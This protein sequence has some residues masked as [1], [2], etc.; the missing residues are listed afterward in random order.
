MT[1]PFS[2]D[3]PTFGDPATCVHIAAWCA[4]RHSEEPSDD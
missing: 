3:S 4:D 1:A 2:W